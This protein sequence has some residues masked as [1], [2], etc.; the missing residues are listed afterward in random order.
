MQISSIAIALFAA[1]GAVANPIATESDGLDA[2]D[3]QLSKY[4]GVI[5][6]YE[7]SLQR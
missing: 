5:S 1:M 2:R 3:T 7:I 6:S 4:G